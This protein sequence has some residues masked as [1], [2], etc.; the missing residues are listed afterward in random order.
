MSEPRPLCFNGQPAESKRPSSFPF[1]GMT[2]FPGGN[3]NQARLYYRLGWTAIVF[4]NAETFFVEE[5]LTFDGMIELIRER[6]PGKFFLRAPVE[7]I[8]VEMD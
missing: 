6:F 7:R 4:W 8:Y 5:I 1:R 2:V 3:A